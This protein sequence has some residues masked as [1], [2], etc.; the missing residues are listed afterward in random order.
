MERFVD[1]KKDFIGKEALSK[2][3][4]SRALVCF[5]ASSRRAPRHD[6]RIV[7]DGRDVGAVTSGSFSP[8]LTCGIGMGYVTGD[9]AIGTAITLK[10]NEI[11]IPA[12][13]VERPFY[14]NGTAK[15]TGGA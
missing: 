15:N 12:V 6:Y 5:Q 4:P 7:K 1:M 10:E 13:I 2:A 14:K 9:P 8:S 11:E 3:R